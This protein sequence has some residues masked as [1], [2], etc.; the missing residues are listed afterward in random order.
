MHLNQSQVMALRYMEPLN[1]NGTVRNSRRVLRRQRAK[2]YTDGLS[3]RHHGICPEAAKDVHRP[4]LL[5]HVTTS[6]WR[7]RKGS[8]FGGTAL[9]TYTRTEIWTTSRPSQKQLFDDSW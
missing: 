3:V 4:K 7:T 9:S 8:V 5:S 1:D 2:A 6:T